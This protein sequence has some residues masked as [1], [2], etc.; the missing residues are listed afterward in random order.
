MG[1]LKRIKE[2]I[3]EILK[4][5]VKG[6]SH[7]KKRMDQGSSFQSI[8]TFHSITM[9][10]LISYLHVA[11][12]I[13]KFDL[14]LPESVRMLFVAKTS[15]FSLSEQVL[16]TDCAYEIRDV[17][18]VFYLKQITSL[19]VIPIVAIFACALFWA[20]A[21]SRR[22]KKHQISPKT[23][24]SP[25]TTIDVEVQPF[26]GFISSIVVLF[27]TL[28]PFLVSRIALTFA[29]QSFGDPA[30]GVNKR[31]LTEALSV[32]CLNSSH[33][34]MLM[35]LGNSYCSAVR[36]HYSWMHCFDTDPSSE[37]EETFCSSAPFS[38]KYHNSFWFYFFR[39]S[40]HE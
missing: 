1:Q 24:G 14:T 26:D 11:G 22:K 35:T 16:L 30:R 39:V 32:E 27:Y 20:C 36:V 29:C 6:N 25:S 9:R 8:T 15:L 37:C 5:R 31:L 23:N 2:M 10:S 21:R 13:L 28:F 38:S 17:E 18:A 12:L 40:A 4:Q 19:W 7:Q 3:P 33:V 34:T